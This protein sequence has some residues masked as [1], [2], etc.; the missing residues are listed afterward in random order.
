MATLKGLLK[1]GFSARQGKEL[2]TLGDGGGDFLVQNQRIAYSSYSIGTVN[3]FGGA[4]LLPATAAIGNQGV[5]HGGLGFWGDEGAGKPLP[6]T[7][8]PTTRKMVLPFDN[9]VYDGITTIF[10]STTNTNMLHERV[11]LSVG[12]VTPH[13]A[14]EHVDQIEGFEVVL[15][16]TQITPPNNPPNSQQLGFQVGVSLGF[17]AILDILY[18]THVITAR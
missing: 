16:W 10:G 8:D 2:L 4:E 9:T 6:I 1:S 13:S 18:I 15:Q 5:S 14:H 7:F 17:G 3:T 12:G 11:V